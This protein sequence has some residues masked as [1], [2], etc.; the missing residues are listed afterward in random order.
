MTMKNNILDKINAIAFDIAQIGGRAFFV[1]GCVR[2]ELL[3]IQSD[4]IDIAV[5]GMDFNQLTGILSKH[6]EKFTPEAVG[7]KVACVIAQISGQKVDFALCRG[8]K[9]TGESHSDFEVKFDVPIEED[10]LRRDLTINAIAKDVLTGEIIDPFDGRKHLRDRTALNVSEAFA[11]DPVRVIRAA[12]FISRFELFPEWQLDMVCHKMRKDFKS[13]P[14]EMIGAEFKKVIKQAKN[15]KAFF[16]FL[17][18]VGWL[19]LAFPEFVGKVEMLEDVSM[20]G[21]FN[22]RLVSL[23][24]VIGQQDSESFLKRIRVFK[25]N[26][27]KQVVCALREKDGF[28]DMFMRFMEGH[29]W[30]M[31]KFLRR[32][33]ENGLNFSTFVIWAGIKLSDEQKMFIRFQEKFVSEKFITGDDL[34]S[35]GMEPGPQFK[36]ILEACINAQDIGILTWE[37]KK[38]FIK[39]RGWEKFI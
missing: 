1:G 35:I 25:E 38:S 3:G 4:D 20:K 27:I 31:R 24:S 11:E 9:K 26:F 14:T 17:N 13:V 29:S 19:E 23:L 33:N 39:E 5:E 37:N 12:R 21:G 7:G 22:R 28:E 15:F 30:E 32:I 8:E 36:A 10:L 34:I 2:D 6:V 18:S 16:S